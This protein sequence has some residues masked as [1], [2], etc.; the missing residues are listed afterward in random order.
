MKKRSR[1]LLISGVCAGGFISSKMAALSA[2][3]LYTELNRR[4]EGD[5]DR[6]RVQTWPAIEPG[7]RG[8]PRLPKASPRP[9]GRPHFMRFCFV[10]IR[11]QNFAFS[12]QNWICLGLAGIS[13]PSPSPHNKRPWGE[14][15]GGGMRGAEVGKELRILLRQIM[16]QYSF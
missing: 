15:K 2:L 5:P 16:V 10:S 6:A 7:S 11:S 12:V 1:V 9:L 3:P 8:L 4:G 14:G 13:P